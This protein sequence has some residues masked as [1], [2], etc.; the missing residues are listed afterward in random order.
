MHIHCCNGSTYGICIMSGRLL[1]PLAASN[2]C[3]NESLCWD[4]TVGICVSVTC[5]NVADAK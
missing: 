5:M 3:S 1:N 2:F 4:G